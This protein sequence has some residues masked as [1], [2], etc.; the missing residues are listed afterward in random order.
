MRGLRSTIALLVVL[1]GLGAYIYF[2]TSK[3]PD[4]GTATATKEKVFPGVEAGNIVEIV[5]KAD[6][7]DTTTL[8]KD[9][10]IWNITMPVAARAEDME[11]S[12]LTSNLNSLEITR[13]VDQ[14]PTD[15]NQYGL[16]TPRIEVDFKSANDKDYHRL[17]LGD[18]SP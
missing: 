6:N 16:Q 2:V 3:M 14:N 1:I 17:F 18:K 9:G 10:S 11:V 13:V 12:Q 4:S 8:K 15:L 7:G 5:V